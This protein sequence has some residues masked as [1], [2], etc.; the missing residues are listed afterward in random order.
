LKIRD[1]NEPFKKEMSRFVSKIV[2][3]TSNLFH[4]NGGLIILL[5]IENE[6]GLVEKDYGTSG[7]QSLLLI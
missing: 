6:Y 5:Q 2:S 1:N 3:V 4:H 7:L